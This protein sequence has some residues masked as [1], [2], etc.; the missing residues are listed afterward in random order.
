MTA[1]AVTVALVLGAVVVVPLGLRLIPDPSGA[2]ARRALALART[3]SWPAGLALALATILPIGIAAGVLAIP[4]LAMA[5]ISAVAA[6]LDVLAAAR[7]GRLLRPGTHHAIWAAQVF[8]AVAATNA[9]AYLLGIQPFGFAPLVVLL[10][11]VHFT[12]AGFA[13]VLVGARTYEARPARWLEAALAALVVGM[14]VTA[15]GFFGVPPATL[16][17][18]LLVA[19]GGL[20]IGAAL[21]RSAAAGTTTTTS[22]RLRRIAGSSLVVSMPLAA[23][24]ATGDVLGL[25]W[26]DIPLMAATHGTLNVLGFAIPAIVALTLADQATAR[27][28]GPARAIDV[29]GFNVAPFVM[30]PIAGI[31]AVFVSLASLPLLIRIPLALAGLAAI[32]MTIA[33]IATTWWVFERSSDRRWAWVAAQAGRP[34]RWVNLTTGFDDSS[35]ILRRSIGGVGRS[36]DVLDPTV[37][38]ERPLMRARRRFPPAGPSVA[39]AAVDAEVEPRGAEVVFLLMAAHE[40][41]GPARTGLLRSAARAITPD[42]RV[43][44]VEHLRNAANIAAFGPG[45]WHFSTRDE[46]LA[47]INEAGLHVVVEARLGPFVTGLTLARAP[48]R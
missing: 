10:T 44:L 32:A 7:D 20:G 8:L 33:A 26:L 14:P 6:A 29:V 41:H 30:G 5:S 47:T 21:L 36:I 31:L 3:L 17:G 18:A 48:G 23:A 2:P 22:R 13:L 25:D 4:W 46:W 28:H 9:V 38:L 15:L 39:P 43:I 40:T 1:I 35:A 45:A 42:G 12:F 24:Y 16:V 19:I 11:A 37:E 34:P 27:P